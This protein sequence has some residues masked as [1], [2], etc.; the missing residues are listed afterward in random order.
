MSSKK[1]IL[2]CCIATALPLLMTGCGRHSIQSHKPL[3][4][5]GC[6][7]NPYLMKYGCSIEKIQQAAENGDP[8]AQYALG[9]MYYYGIDTVRDSETATLWIKRASDQGQPLAKKALS[10]MNSGVQFTDFHQSVTGNSETAAA[11]GSGDDKP[12]SSNTIV[13][14]KGEDVTKLNSGTPAE[15]LSHHLPAYR[16]SQSSKKDVLSAKPQ[17]SN[18][19]SAESPSQT[20]LS[21]LK[22]TDPR[23]T[24]TAEPIV[25]KS[26]SQGISSESNT[27]PSKM[28][29]ATDTQLA[30]NDAG[31]FTMQ[32][33]ASDKLS[34]LKS[35]AKA[36]QLD[37]QAHYYHTSLRGKSWYML[38]YGKYSSEKQAMEAL[39]QLPKNLKSY[40]PW[41]KSFATV[42]EEVRLNRVI[43]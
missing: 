27:T 31:D 23:L 42:E 38:T 18:A 39:S 5:V 10:L 22:I 37:N 4:T 7:N 35:F 32:L 36:N 11:P 33:M 19:A 29:T 3:Y 24:S 25:A 14:Q 13:Y 16:H 28:E 40:H 8:D 21:S 34:D 6:S 15:P 17:D 30:S 43:A 2:L 1:L 12:T 20:N 9:Y 41:V 26:V